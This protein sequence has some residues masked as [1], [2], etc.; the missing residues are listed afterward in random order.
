MISSNLIVGLLA[1][2]SVSGFGGWFNFFDSPPSPPPE[3]LEQMSSSSEDFD[4]AV[5]GDIDIAEEQAFSFFS[6]STWRP[7]LG[8]ARQQ[9]FGAST[10]NRPVDMERG[11]ASGTRPIMPRPRP[12]MLGGSD[13]SGQMSPTSSPYNRPP[14]WPQREPGGMDAPVMMPV[15]NSSGMMQQPGMG[16]SGVN[17]QNSQM[18]PMPSPGTNQGYTTTGAGMG[19]GTYGAPPMPPSLPQ[20]MNQGMGGGMMGGQE[21]G[22]GAG[23]QGSVP[24]GLPNTLPMPPEGAMV[25]CKG[26]DTGSAC[27][28]FDRN[29]K[30]SGTC[31]TPP[32]QPAAVCVPT[33]MLSM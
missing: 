19:G 11:N 16:V 21:P 32:G 13:A 20:G 5:A 25:A 28:F 33:G 2:A 17:V 1:A 3:I 12:G 22:A 18:P 30:M 4:V 29:Q 26:K 9:Y 15:G 31:Q 27:E 24:G 23:M 7:A 6:P 14:V 10:G 8:R